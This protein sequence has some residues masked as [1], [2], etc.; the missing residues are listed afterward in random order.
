[1]T[2][3]KNAATGADVTATAPDGT[4]A[5]ASAA[6]AAPEVP[7]AS[8]APVD[9]PEPVQDRSAALAN[10]VNGADA[11]EAPKAPEAPAVDPEAPRYDLGGRTV[12]L[13]TFA[14]WNTLVDGVFKSAKRGALVKVTAAEADR[15]ER[16]GGLVRVDA[17]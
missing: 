7:A 9:P 14:R 16:L 11:A 4:T 17:D 5:A 13:V 2:A 8:V 15:G 6:A 12:C 10:L 1:M 3:R